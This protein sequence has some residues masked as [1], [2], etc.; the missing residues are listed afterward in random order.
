VIQ[1]AIEKAWHGD[2]ICRVGVMLRGEIAVSSMQVSL[3]GE[4][5]QHLTRWELRH[6]HHDKFV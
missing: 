3:G 1:L 2:C 6:L 5:L 4:W